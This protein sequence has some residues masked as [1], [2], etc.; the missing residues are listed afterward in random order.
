[1]SS[2]LRKEFS[3]EEES[4]VEHL[5]LLPTQAKEKNKTKK[6]SNLDYKG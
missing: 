3:Y 4:W 1:M 6:C 5:N 2:L